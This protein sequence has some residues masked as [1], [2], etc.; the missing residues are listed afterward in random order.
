[1]ENSSPKSVSEKIPFWRDIRVLRVLFQV[2]FLIGVLLLAGILYTN[3]LRGLR[4]LGLTL[5]LDFLN[6]EAGFGISE[7]IAYEPS[8]TYLRAFERFVAVR[9]DDTEGSVSDDYVYEVNGKPVFAEQ[10]PIKEEIAV[11]EWIHAGKLTPVVEK[12]I[13]D[14]QKERDELEDMELQ[15]VMTPD[16]IVHHV[17][18]PEDTPYEEGDTV[19]ADE[20]DA[21]LV[22]SPDAVNRLMYFSAIVDMDGTEHVPPD[23]YFEIDDNRTYAARS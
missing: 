16:G 21:E 2:I 3:M 8:D 12:L 17:L 1:M 5:N 7:G 18:V 20:L 23:A 22:M 13:A 15:R 10:P 11:S 9:H 14:A 6:D 4:G 19:Y